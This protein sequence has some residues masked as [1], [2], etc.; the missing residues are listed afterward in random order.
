MF[1]LQA[2]FDLEPSLST[3]LKWCTLAASAALAFSV[4]LGV[5]SLPSLLSG[6]KNM[7]Q[8]TTLFE[9]SWDK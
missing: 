7:C 4:Q 1:D 9:N 8:T 2:N 5:Q 6:E 3:T